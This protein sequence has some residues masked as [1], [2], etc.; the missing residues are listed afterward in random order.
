MLEIFMISRLFENR[1]HETF[2]IL[3]CCFFVFSL[4]RFFLLSKLERSHVNIF[5]NRT[6]ILL[7]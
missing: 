6:N 1:H 5:E 2:I 4:P 3:S 7:N